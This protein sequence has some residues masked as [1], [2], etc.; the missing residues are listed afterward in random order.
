MGSGQNMS[1]S[2]FL[3]L[4]LFGQQ[5]EQQQRQQ[6][7]KSALSDEDNNNFDTIPPKAGATDT[8]D[9]PNNYIPNKDP[10]FNTTN[11][12]RILESYRMGEIPQMMQGTAEYPIDKSYVRRTITSKPFYVSVHDDIIDQV[13]TDLFLNGRYYESKL[14]RII[15]NVFDRKQWSPPSKRKGKNSIMIDVGGNIGWFSLLAAAH[16]AEVFT[17]EPNIINMVRFCESQ[18]LNGWVSPTNERSNRIHSYLKG[19]SNTHGTMQPMFQVSSNNPGS[20]TFSNHST[21]LHNIT[22]QTKEDGTLL[23]L[24]TLDALA[25]DQGWLSSSEE[26]KTKATK[27]ESNKKTISTSHRTTSPQPPPSIGF[28]KIDVEGLELSVLKGATRLLNAKLVE[29]IAMEFKVAMGRRTLIEIVKILFDSG[30]EAYEIGGWQGPSDTILSSKLVSQYKSPSFFITELLARFGDKD[31]N[32]WF[33]LA[34]E[35]NYT[36]SVHH[37]TTTP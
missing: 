25:L 14:S 36:D 1:A 7:G 13:R 21:K 18:M 35:S 4:N 33:R 9:G 11:C 6:G 29:N 19:V 16:G 3:D 27:E 22:P 24:I 31:S 10:F 37:D 28:L 23:P 26:S 15:Q 17:F 8:A 20:F 2:D 12:H 5:Q 30:Y 34:T 32:V